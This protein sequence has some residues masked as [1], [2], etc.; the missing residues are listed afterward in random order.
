MLK[1]EVDPDQEIS[2]KQL[3][4]SAKEL[5]DQL[6]LEWYKKSTDLD[7]CGDLL[8]QLK[9]ISEMFIH[10]SVFVFIYVVVIT[11]YVSGIFD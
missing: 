9:V 10:L 1:M 7:K 4:S 5:Y 2:K 3:F 11:F 6:R 8:S